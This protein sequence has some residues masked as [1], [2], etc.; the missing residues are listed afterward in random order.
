MLRFKEESP[1]D[2]NI[3]FDPDYFKEEN[4]RLQCRTPNG[5][6]L[7]F[8]QILRRNSLVPKKLEILRRTVQ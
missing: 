3:Y 8:D 7:D 1:I 2:P 5:K 4:R 6:P